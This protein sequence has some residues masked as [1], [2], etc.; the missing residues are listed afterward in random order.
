MDYWPNED[1]AEWFARDVLPRIQATR[2]DVRFYIVGTRPSERVRRLAELPG[3]HV[4]G[5]VPDVRP[6]LQHADVAVAPLRIA[7]GIQNKVLEAMAMAKP[8]VATAEAAEGVNAVLNSE[9]FVAKEA[10]DFADRV[11]ALV[12]T[13]QAAEAGARARERVLVAYDWSANLAAFRRLLD[14]ERCGREAV[15]PRLALAAET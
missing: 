15:A 5:A 2:S 12:G 1:A 6:Y 9:L 8:V 13:R 3:V 14:G 7:R 11:L 10:A 4:T